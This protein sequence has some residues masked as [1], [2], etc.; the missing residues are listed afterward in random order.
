MRLLQWPIL[1]YWHTTNPLFRYDDANMPGIAQFNGKQI[2]LATT[3]EAIESLQRHIGDG[4]I[5]RASISYLKALIDLHSYCV[6]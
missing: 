6:E 1:L 3:P 4:F 2:S 5:A